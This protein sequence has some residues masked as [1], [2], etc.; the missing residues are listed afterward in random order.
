MEFI[1]PT[2]KLLDGLRVRGM[3]P[4]DNKSLYSVFSRQ[5]MAGMWLG[6]ITCRDGA[7]ARDIVSRINGRGGKGLVAKGF[8]RVGTGGGKSFFCHVGGIV[9]FCIFKTKIETIIKTQ[10]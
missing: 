7:M 9:Y 3:E 8:W 4:T 10:I 1:E 2:Y 5:P 6:F